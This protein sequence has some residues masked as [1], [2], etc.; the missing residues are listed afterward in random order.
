MSRL[1]Q[2]TVGFGAPFAPRPPAINI[3]ESPQGTR[4][5]LRPMDQCFN[6]IFSSLRPQPHSRS[7]RTLPAAPAHSL[8]CRR[9]KW[10]RSGNPLSLFPKRAVRF[11]S[12]DWLGGVG[13]LCEAEDKQ[14]RCLSPFCFLGEFRCCPRRAV[15]TSRRRDTEAKGQGGPRSTEK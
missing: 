8:L 12:E 11:L 4:L 15:K 9:L 1:Y 3:P 5:R 13:S 10:P 14:H 2:S 6:R 7:P